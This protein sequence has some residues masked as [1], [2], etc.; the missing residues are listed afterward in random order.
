MFLM[1]PI[2]P[3]RNALEAACLAYRMAL[4]LPPTHDDRRSLI[5]FYLDEASPH[6]VR[7]VHPFHAMDREALHAYYRH[8]DRDAATMWQEQFSQPLPDSV[9]SIWA[10]SLSPYR[11]YWDAPTSL[12][13]EEWD[14]AENYAGDFTMPMLYLMVEGLGWRPG[15]PVA[16]DAEG[17]IAVWYEE[18]HCGAYLWIIRD[19]LG[20]SDVDLDWVPPAVSVLQAK[21]GG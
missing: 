1:E 16:E 21:F 17:W 6:W 8:A 3:P 14:I 9:D 7:T 13:S 10:E 2:R 12:S 4:P 18:I 20:M 15:T 5:Q 19:I 11:N